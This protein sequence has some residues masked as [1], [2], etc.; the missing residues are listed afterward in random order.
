MKQNIILWIAAAII[1][2]VVA[3]YKTLT[4]DYYPLSGSFGIEGEKVT[5]KF[6]KIYQ[7]VFM[8]Y[9]RHGHFL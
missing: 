5:F 3:Y 4:S 6:D 2:F 7:M 1:L 9:A 8:N